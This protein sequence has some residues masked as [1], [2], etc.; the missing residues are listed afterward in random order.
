MMTISELVKNCSQYSWWRLGTGYG[1]KLSLTIGYTFKKNSKSIVLFSNAER[2][3]KETVK[4][5]Y[6]DCLKQIS[7]LEKV[8]KCKALKGKP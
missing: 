8:H 6:E 4:E 5:L 1:G 3:H 2:K 7:H